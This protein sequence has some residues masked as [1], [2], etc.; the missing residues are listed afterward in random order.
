MENYSKKR[1]NN[2]KNRQVFGICKVKNSIDHNIVFVIE[3]I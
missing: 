1:L 3:K 2:D